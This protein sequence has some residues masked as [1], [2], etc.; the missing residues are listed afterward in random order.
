VV[1]NGVAA[2]AAAVAQDKLAQMQHLEMLQQ[3]LRNEVVN[4]LPLI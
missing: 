2:A 3:Q 4:L 1:G